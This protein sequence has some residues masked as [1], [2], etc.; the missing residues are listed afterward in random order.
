[1]AISGESLLNQFLRTYNDVFSV[2]DLSKILTA[3]GVPFRNSEIAEFLETDPLIFPLEQKMYLTRSGA[4]TGQYFSFVLDQSEV[5]Q[6]AFVPGDR[7]M[8][9]V[10]TELLSCFI[11]F[12]YRGTELPQKVIEID[13]NT[14]F[15]FFT[16]FGD[17]YASQY[18]AADPVN[19][20]LDLIAHEFE[21]PARIKMTGISLE[22]VIHDCSLK[23]GDRII[24]RV[25]DWDKSIIEI[26]PQPVRRESP[27]KV[28]ESDVAHQRWNEQLEKALLESFTRMGPCTSIEEQLAN[29]FY[30]C[31]HELCTQQC[32]SVSE[33]I[34]QAKNISMELFGVETRLWRTGEIV[35]AVGSWNRN[36]LAGA[37]SSMPSECTVPDYILDCFIE[38]EFFH[39]TNDIK[40]LPDRILPA[41]VKLSPAER[42][43]L[44]LHILDRND[45][46]QRRYNWFADFDLGSIRHRAL[47]LYLQVG[48]LVY[49]LDGTAGSLEQLPQQE[50]VTLSQLFTHIMRILETIANDPSGAADEAAAIELSVEGMEYNFEDIQEELSSAADE[51]RADT[52]EV[53]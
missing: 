24:C 26:F 25:C 53:I 52:F 45:I 38:D 30:E 7:C 19:S 50:L 17:E 36:D 3:A 11:R 6:E 27:F 33:Y 43:L 23:P 48:S 39:H 20:D 1:M 14:A 10:D 49:D 29:V 37:S 41:A 35:P 12:V 16:L 5:V 44:T 8:P 46:L 31:R 2:R 21:L 18:I 13:R 47:E 34:T 9:F 40:S 42:K 4:F 22:P 15:E 51:L 28:N 32:G